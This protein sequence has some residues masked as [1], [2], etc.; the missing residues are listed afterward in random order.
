LEAWRA[1]GLGRITLWS[2]PGLSICCLS[3]VAIVT[4]SLRTSM[5][6]STHFPHLCH[7]DELWLWF[8]VWLQAV[9]VAQL[10]SLC[11]PS[12]LSLMHQLLGARTLLLEGRPNCE[13]NLLTFLWLKQVTWPRLINI[14]RA[15]K[16]LDL[17]Q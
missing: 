5:P 14:R 9:G 3:S 2:R 17:C 7:A 6:Y 1:E 11:L 15:G 12:L 10:C 13:C 16:V 8:Q 4:H